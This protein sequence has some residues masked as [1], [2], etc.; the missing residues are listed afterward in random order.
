[1]DTFH[2]FLVLNPFILDFVIHFRADLY[3]P[4]NPEIALFS[5]KPSVV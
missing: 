3:K 5:C 1:M 4:E 2:L